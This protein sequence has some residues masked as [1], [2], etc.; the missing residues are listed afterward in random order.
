MARQI[1]LMGGTFDPIHYGHLVV[2][3]MARDELG[4]D[5]VIFVPSGRPPHKRQRVIS[6]GEDRCA[7]TALAIDSNPHFQLSRFE[8]ESDDYSYTLTTV[9]HFRQRYGEETSLWFITG[10]DAIKEIL[11]W[12][13]ANELVK[14][15]HFLAAT[16]PGYSTAIPPDLQGMVVKFTVPALA[17][18]STEIRAAVAA[19]RSIKYLLPE[20]VEDYIY[21]HHLYRKENHV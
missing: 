21:I 15:C 20:A 6:S 3:E 10:A 5:E 12:Y 16:R 14:K 2:A 7:M 18:S 11:N 1:G 4:L 13:K 17:I 8:V 19:G 9:N